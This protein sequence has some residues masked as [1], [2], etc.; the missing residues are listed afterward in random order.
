VLLHAPPSAHW[1]VPLGHEL[2]QTP[3]T[4]LSP[5]SQIFPQPPQFSRSV[6]VLVHLPSQACSPFVHV[7]VHVPDT[8]A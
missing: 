8:H 6:R 2:V 4:Q 7:V 1:V 5:A 3:A